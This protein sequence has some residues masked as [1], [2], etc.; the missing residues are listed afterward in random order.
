MAGDA[1]ARLCRMLDGLPL[2]IELAAHWVGH[3]TPDEIV[4]AIQ[5]DLDFLAA[6]TRDIPDRHR[7]LRAV[8]DYAWRSLNPAEQQSLMRTSVFHGSFDRAAAQAVAHVR[9]TTLVTL[10]DKSLLQQA[11][12]GRYSLHELLRQF[13][14]ERLDD[15]GEAT[16]MR[17]QHAAYYLALAEQAAPEL[18]RPDQAAAL[19]RLDRALDNLRAALSWVWEQGQIDLGLRLAGALERFWFTRGYLGEGQEWIERFLLTSDSAAVSPAVRAQA[20]SAAGLLANTQGD[21]LQATR[22]LEL[23]LA[24]YRAADDLAGAVRV[25]TTLGGV[26][27]DQGDLRGALERWEQSLAQARAVG[28]LGE[29]AR[30]LGN[31][32][33]AYY[34]LGDLARAAAHHTEALALAL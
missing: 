12:I 22:W 13:A 4:E 26:A 30:A 20:Y 21:H 9:A 15:S 7:S 24:S 33:E 23:G 1:V 11:A 8:F 27:Y 10:A 34:H 18:A 31:L 28:D 6:R 14:A 2:A 25:L 19:E 32:G 5:A 29:V 3:Y 16:A 17:A